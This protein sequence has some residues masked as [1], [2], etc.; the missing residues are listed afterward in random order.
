MTAAATTGPNKHPRPTSST[1]ATSLAP[2]AQ[3]FFSNFRVHFRRLSK[4]IFAAAAESFFATTTGI[5]DS[6]GGISEDIYTRQFKRKPGSNLTQN[7]PRCNS[8]L[9]GADPKL[10]TE[11]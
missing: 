10:N 4:R 6:A 9:H 1:P 2:P 11:Y 3:A 8:E 7:R 5:A